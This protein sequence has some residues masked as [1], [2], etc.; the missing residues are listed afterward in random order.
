V[1]RVVAAL[2]GLWILTAAAPAA[3]DHAADLRATRAH[4]A[5]RQRSALYALYSSDST[6][7]RAR[8]AAATAGSRAQALSRQVTVAREEVAVARH[9][10]DL[11]RH[12]LM[13][14]LRAWY[15]NGGTVDPL[16]LI[17]T[18]KS[19]DDALSQDDAYQRITAQDQQ[20]M[21]AARN[22]GQEYRSA[23]TRVTTA[24]SEALAEQRS[25]QAQVDQLVAEQQAR[26][27]LIAHLRQQRA[28][29]SSQLSQLQATARQAAERTATLS[30]PASTPVSSPA[31]VPQATSVAAPS[32]GRQI[33]VS[34]TAY[35]LP[36]HT[37]S[38]LPVGPGIC[39]VDPSVIPMG[40]RFIVPGYGTCIAAD[41]GSAIIG[42]R[43]D[44]WF[45]TFA[46]A[47]AWGRQTV[48]ITLL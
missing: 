44:L 48:T 31:P 13:L 24:R 41:R 23:L 6:I 14:R 34:A 3:A 28:G 30:A 19:I 11:S 21:D 25:A 43:I 9:N 4:L 27:D 7:A 40:T 32:S 2:L 10:L 17:L 35:S 22:A 37:S 15:K 1:R 5:A 33:V 42:A 39:A 29:V 12:N 18:S 8:A 16:E 26:R 36:G 20:V 47:A 38:G 45:A 46:Q